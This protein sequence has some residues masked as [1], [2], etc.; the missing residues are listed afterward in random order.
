MEG[1]LVLGRS[2]ALV[3]GSARDDEKEIF[4]EYIYMSTA[5]LE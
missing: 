2:Q 3:P 5:M 1:Y 4:L